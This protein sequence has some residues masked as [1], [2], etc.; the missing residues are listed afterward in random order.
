MAH[1]RTSIK[2][3][4]IVTADTVIARYELQLPSKYNA[5]KLVK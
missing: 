4:V 3:F 1:Q 2:Q 5:F